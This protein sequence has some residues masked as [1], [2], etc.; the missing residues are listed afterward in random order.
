PPRPP[1]TLTRSGRGVPPSTA[2]GPGR[3]PARHPEPVRDVAVDLPVLQ[4][5]TRK[6]IVERRDAVERGLRKKRLEREH[7]APA[8]PEVR[9]ASPIELYP[10]RRVLLG[11]WGSRPRGRAPLSRGE[12]RCGRE[13][14]HEHCTADQLPHTDNPPSEE[15]TGA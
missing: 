6:E 3:A 15:L 9:V 8:D 12:R 4:V 7:A 5:I 2:V 13:H 11:A 10:E 14:R 1:R